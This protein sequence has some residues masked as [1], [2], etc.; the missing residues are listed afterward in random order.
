MKPSPVRAAF[1]AILFVFV[2]PSPAP[3]A[4]SCSAVADNPRQPAQIQ[5]DGG[6]FP[7]PPS[8]DVKDCSNISI[9]GGRVVLMFETAAGDA[10]SLVCGSD[11][12]RC[13][14]PDGAKAIL[15]GLRARLGGKG[16]VAAL[17]GGPERRTA[18]KRYDE[19]SQRPE[20]LPSG[21]I[22]SPE[23]AGLFDF[24]ALGGGSWSLVVTR[25]PGRAA[26]IQRSGSDPIVQFPPSLF[27]RGG[28]YGWVLNA[29]G[30][31]FT[32]GFDVLGPAPA[33]E[34]ER[35]LR[36]AGVTGGARTRKQQLD[37]LMVLVE[38]DL[39][40][41]ARILYRELGL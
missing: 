21:K 17:Q 31:R 9:A 5:A 11:G 41:E 30:K 38:H 3:A 34:V 7:I 18:A 12:H 39:D 20:G 26:I 22:Y 10:R 8:R 23:R 36:D 1:A 27:Q 25:E 28:K 32:G 35:D 14:V 6:T 37:E 2:L 4:T 13:V 19:D 29:G 16:V 33:A 15:N 40:H 24:R